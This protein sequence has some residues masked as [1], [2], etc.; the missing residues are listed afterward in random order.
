VKGAKKV[1][2][3]M[4]LQISSRRLITEHVYIDT[5]CWLVRT[6]EFQFIILIS[7]LLTTRTDVAARALPVELTAPGH[8]T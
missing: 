4:Y 6:T 5:D 8:P 7:G 1:R 3:D 2:S